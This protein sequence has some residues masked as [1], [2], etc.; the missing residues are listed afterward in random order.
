LVREVDVQPSHPDSSLQDADLSSYNFLK[1]H[2]RGFLYT[3]PF[4][5]KSTTWMKSFSPKSL[6]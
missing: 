1:I 6:N 2:Y 3:I 5:K 4:K